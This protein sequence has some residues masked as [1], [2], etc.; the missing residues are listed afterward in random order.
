MN[1]ALPDKH[2][3]NSTS[4]L[5]KWLE[6]GNSE[7]QKNRWLLATRLQWNGLYCGRFRW[8][9]C[10]YRFVIVDLY[11]FGKIFGSHHQMI[12]VNVSNVRKSFHFVESDECADEVTNEKW[13]S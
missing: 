12:K 7:I 9:F 5:F 11:D 8:C 3:F 10:L 2:K 1:N 13:L 4:I 6:G